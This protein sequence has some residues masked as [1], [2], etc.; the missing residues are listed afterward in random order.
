MISVSLV[1]SLSCSFFPLELSPIHLLPGW[2]G[3]CDEVLCKRSPGFTVPRCPFIWGPAGAS[4]LIGYMR[5]SMASWEPS[6]EE[7]GTA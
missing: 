5:L 3:G 6:E 1:T 2:L 4:N 7:E